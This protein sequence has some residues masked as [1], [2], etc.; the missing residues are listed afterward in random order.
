MIRWLFRLLIVGLVLAIGLVLVKDHLLKELLAAH[1]QRETGLETRVGRFELG[2]LSPT[3]TIEELRIYNPAEFGGSVFLR[4][5]ECH[6]E[7]DPAAL[8]TRRIHLRLFRLNLAEATVV[9]HSAGRSNLESIG[10]R[11]HRK[12]AADRGPEFAFGGLDML[13]LTLGRLHRV[14][15]ANPSRV[16]TINL[17]VQNEIYTNLR[18]SSD[19]F[20]A[21]GQLALRVGLSQ[22][23]NQFPIRPDVSG[24]AP[25][26]HPGIVPRPPVAPAVPSPR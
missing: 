2:L 22:L 1:I 24:L 26:A 8:L 21:L 3:L 13:N 23:T 4:V 15:L 5:A 20:L 12:K 11:L 19:V 10:E 25:P 17:G 16:Q 9:E 18:T 6:I 7:Y 14:T